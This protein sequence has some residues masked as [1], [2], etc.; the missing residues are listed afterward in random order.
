MKCKSRFLT[1]KL[2][3]DLIGNFVYYDA[4][5]DFRLQKSYCYFCHT[6]A[7]L[8]IPD[9]LI[10]IPDDQLGPQVAL[11]STYPAY[12]P[13]Y[14]PAGHPLEQFYSSIQLEL[15]LILTSKM[16]FYV[17]DKQIL[18]FF[19]PKFFLSPNFFGT[20]NLFRPKIYSLPTFF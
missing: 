19:D 15:K 16:K 6:R 3:V 2:I 17:H 8:T 4:N 1:I 9:P 13:A 5:N 18:N 14:Q 10:I 20:Q 11:Y 12:R 7:Q